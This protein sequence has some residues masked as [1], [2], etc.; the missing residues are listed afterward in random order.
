MAYLSGGYGRCFAM[1]LHNIKKDTKKRKGAGFRLF[2]GKLSGLRAAEIFMVF[3]LLIY[4]AL[5]FFRGNSR[6]VD[7]SVISEAMADQCSEDGLRSGDTGTFKR[8]FG[9]DSSQY[10]G[11][12]MYISDNLMNVDELLIV[13]I[14]DAGQLNE[15][16]DAVNA[17]LASQ[18]QNFHGYGTNQEAL[19]QNAVVREQGRYFFYAVS[20]QAE[21]WEEIF[22]SCIR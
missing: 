7:I 12:V 10:E 1:N 19:L 5:V 22:L 20:G 16:E 17:R 14:S 13:K 4:M 21:Q 11:Y 2:G 9:L 18:I 6:D 15:L 3:F 8:Y